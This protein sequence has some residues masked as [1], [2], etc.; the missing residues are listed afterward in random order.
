MNKAELISVMASKSGQTKM[1]SE[2]MVNAFVATVTE[3]L[4]KGGTV[5]LLGFGT[6]KPSAL[7][8]RVGR[9]PQ[10][11]VSLKIP[12]TTRPMF[13]AG[14]RFKEQVASASKPKAASRVRKGS[15]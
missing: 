5:Q 1:V 7:A 2:L 10:T 3:T 14:S 9:N 12:A 11:G 8:E 4:A 13:V 15:R 6:F